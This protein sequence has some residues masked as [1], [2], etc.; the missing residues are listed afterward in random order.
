FLNATLPGGVLG[1]VH[2]AVRHG[3]DVGDL[4]GSAR[5]VVAERGAG[6]VVQ[7]AVS[8]AVLLALPSPFRSRVLVTGALAVAGFGLVALLVLVVRRFV[9][10]AAVSRTPAS[11]TPV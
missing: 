6:Q 1:D 2:R 5:A 8:L 10:R 11:S 4:G 3:R 9:R 7:I